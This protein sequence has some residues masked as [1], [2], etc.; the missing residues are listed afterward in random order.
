MDLI[1]EGS[2]RA[3]TLLELYARLVLSPAAVLLV[4]CL[5]RRFKGLGATVDDLVAYT[6]LP[7]ANIKGALD[8]VPTSICYK[9]SGSSFDEQAEEDQGNGSDTLSKDTDNQ[10]RYYINYRSAL[11]WVVA[12]SRRIL[13]QLCKTDR[14]IQP[15]RPLSGAGGIAPPPAAANAAAMP[16]HSKASSSGQSAV[17][18]RSNDGKS[19]YCAGCTTWFDLEV[20]LRTPAGN[21]AVCNNNIVMSS[22][23]A[24]KA[25]W[26][27]ACKANPNTLPGHCG[28]LAPDG[29]PVAS[30]LRMDRC[31]LQQAL[32][33]CHLMSKPFCFVDAHHAVV[34]PDAVM[35]VDEL[36]DRAKHRSS[37]AL[38][39]RAK[40]RSGRHLRLQLDVGLAQREQRALAAN[41]VRLEKRHALPPWLRPNSSDGAVTTGAPAS[42]AKR[43]REEDALLPWQAVAAHAKAVVE[44]HSIES[45]EDMVVV[46]RRA[47]PS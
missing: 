7:S 38:Q 10:L 24:A 30:L 2:R 34:D 11:P 4:D 37:L 33:L 19:L 26:D 1:G 18:Q 13:L 12:H 29:H 14:T 25:A 17:K 46:F 16:A 27:V 45:M 39:F 23:E 20:D 3:A 41:R 15:P 32:A 6:G 9:T 31:V 22:L 42:N 35:T 28:K 36:N 40:H 5:T 43:P 8:E 44:R 47:E 21:C